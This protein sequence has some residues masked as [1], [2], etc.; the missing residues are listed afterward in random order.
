LKLWFGP[1][2]GDVWPATVTYA[3]VSTVTRHGLSPTQ[4]WLTRLIL[5]FCVMGTLIYK[6]TSALLLRPLLVSRRFTKPPI[7]FFIAPWSPFRHSWRFAL[8][9]A[10]SIFRFPA[11]VIFCLAF[12]GAGTL[13]V[14][15]FSTASAFR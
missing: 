11:P 10:G 13:E 7:C 2:G 12:V 8:V 6:P 9:S 14:A 3:P 5:E 4:P 1:S 15:R